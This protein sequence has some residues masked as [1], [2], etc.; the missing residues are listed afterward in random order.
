MTDVDK[1]AGTGTAAAEPG[2]IDITGLVNF[3]SAEEAHGQ[4]PAVVQ[5]EGVG[6]GVDCLG[7]YV[8]AEAQPV[9]RHAALWAGFQGKRG[10][11]PFFIGNAADSGRNSDAEVDKSARSKV[12]RRPAGNQLAVRHGQGGK[13]VRLN[14]LPAAEFGPV[15]RRVALT[16]QVRGCRHQIVDETSVRNH[17]AGIQR[18]GRHDLFDFRNH[19]S[20]AVVCCGGNAEGHIAHGL[21]LHGEIPIGVGERRADESRCLWEM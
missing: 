17:V 15:N 21:I 8:C 11:N 9:Q 6:Q 20:A 18:S 14:A 16:V 10:V 2:N 12:Y 19:D 13:R 1:T 4:H 3:R 7:V 5:M